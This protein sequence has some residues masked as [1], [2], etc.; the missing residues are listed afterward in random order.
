MVQNRDLALMGGAR[1]SKT[2]QI[3]VVDRAGRSVVVAARTGLS[4]MENIRG[5][6]SSVEAVCGGMCACATCH[7]LVAADW[8]RALPPRSYE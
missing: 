7:V 1:D 5:L 2:V 6:D 3:T 8:V 4:V